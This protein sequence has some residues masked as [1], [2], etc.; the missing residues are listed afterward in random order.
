MVH[1]AHRLLHTAESFTP[2][3]RVK[4]DYLSR[5]RDY[6]RASHDRDYFIAL[7]RDQRRA[8]V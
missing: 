6:A 3:I 8:Y 4:I 2:Q 1:E 5:S 7:A